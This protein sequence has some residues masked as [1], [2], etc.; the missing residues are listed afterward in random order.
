MNYFNKSD[1]HIFIWLFTLTIMTFLMILIGGLTRLT[2]SGLSM[3]DWQPITGSLP[4]LNANDWINA[5]NSY[6]LSPEFI[7]INKSMTLI[8]FKFIFWWEWSHR[9]FA[10]AIGLVFIFPMIFF[11]IN[12]K[13][14]IKL[15]LGLTLLFL[16]GL[17]QAIIGWWMVKSGLNENPYVSQ[18]RLAFHLTN[19]VIILSIFFWLTINS[20]FKTN[21]KYIPNNIFEKL[22]FILLFILFFTIISGAFMAGTNAG[23][24]FNTFPLMNGNIFPDDY[25]MYDLGIKNFFEN[26]VAINFNLRWIATIC[27]VLILFLSFYI[28]FVSKLKNQFIGV[29]LIFTFSI[30]QFSLGILT[31]IT[32]VKI[33][34]ASMHQVNSVLL[35]TSLIFVYYSIK[36]ERISS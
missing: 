22:V 17:F 19:A 18:Y 34:L 23:Q 33:S 6:K 20:W 7:I 35:L 15:I 26:T 24:S 16:F 9:F 3:V 11:I 8:E 31:L 21:I 29:I 30:I 36:K 1:R 4:P 27:F 12:K 5:F 32:N 13:L 14:N 28:Y 2:D 10:R 25:Y